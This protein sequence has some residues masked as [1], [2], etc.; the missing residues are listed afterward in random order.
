[1]DPR[2]LFTLEDM[3][4]DTVLRSGFQTRIFVGEQ[5]AAYVDRLVSEVN[6][7]TEAQSMVK[8]V[9]DNGLDR[10]L[11]LQLSA[12]AVGSKDGVYG[13]ESGVDSELAL[14]ASDALQYM[15]QGVQLLSAAS[16][17]TAFAAHLPDQNARQGQKFRFALPFTPQPTAE[18]PSMPFESLPPNMPG[19][20][21]TS[22]PIV[23]DSVYCMKLPPIAP[24]SSHQV[25]LPVYV[26]QP[27]QHRIEYELVDGAQ[28][29]QVV[30][31][32]L[33][34]INGCKA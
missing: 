30:E 34:I 27:G 2:S 8:V 3:Y 4:M 26:V 11:Q 5:Q 33:L 20:A 29:A 16:V 13:V 15:A 32:G 1:M 19:A 25:A 7:P 22:Q 23:F 17:N 9:V 14:E 18:L 10:M 21:P 6:C 12:R 31:R 24:G 28:A